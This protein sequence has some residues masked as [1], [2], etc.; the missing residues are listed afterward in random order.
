MFILISQS[1]I[2]PRNKSKSEE[3]YEE[4]PSS[5]IGRFENGLFHP[6]ITG[7]GF[8]VTFSG[9]HPVTNAIAP[10]VLVFGK[11]LLVLRVHA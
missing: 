8:T 11:A 5:A 2:Q 1:K 3:A 10:T 4:Q 9:I 7:G 6:I